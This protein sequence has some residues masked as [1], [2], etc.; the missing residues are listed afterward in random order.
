M[1][2]AG[3]ESLWWANNIRE[4]VSEVIDSVPVH[5]MRADHVAKYGHV[6]LML[7]LTLSGRYTSLCITDFIQN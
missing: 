3:F 1:Q 7:I 4:S 5:K 2:T 6:L